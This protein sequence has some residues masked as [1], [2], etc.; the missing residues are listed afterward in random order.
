M[1]NWKSINWKSIH[2]QL[3]ELNSRIE[4]DSIPH[5]FNGDASGWTVSECLKWINNENQF[6]MPENLIP[7]FGTYNS[8]GYEEDCAFLLIDSVTGKFYEISGSHCSC[9]G[10]ENQFTPEECPLEY[11][12]KGKKWESA[13]ETVLKV[14]EY[15]ANK[16]N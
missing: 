12:S 1:T 11:L 7:I 9:Y 3:L 6:S 15:F 16:T 4:L 2:T 5:L 14:V 8:Y 10:F 13:F